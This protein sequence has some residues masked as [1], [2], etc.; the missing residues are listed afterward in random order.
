MHVGHVED[1]HAQAGIDG[2]QGAQGLL[3][4]AEEQRS[5][6]VI[7]QHTGQIGGGCPRGTVHAQQA[8]FGEVDDALDEQDRGQTHADGHGNDHVEQDGETEAGEQ[9]H[10][11]AARRAAQ[12]VHEMARL[13]HVPCGHE[14]ETRERRHR[15]IGQQIRQGDD[16]DEHHA[17]MD[18]AGQRRAGSGADVGRGAGDGGRGR[19]TA[20][21][22]RDDVAQALPHQ[23]GIGIVARARHAVGDHGAQQRFQRAQHGDGKGR[24]EQIL[25]QRQGQLER[26]AVRAG[27]HP[28][29][30][31]LRQEGRDAV[32]DLGARRPREARAN[33]VHGPFGSDSRQQQGQQAPRQQRHQMA[34]KAQTQTRPK[35][36]DPQR[37]RPDEQIGGVETGQGAQQDAQLVPVMAFERPNGQPQEILQLQGGDHDRDAAG[38]AHRDRVGHQLDEAA[39]ARQAHEQQDHAGHGAGGEQ[40]AEAEALGDGQQHHH[41]CSRRPR[42]V[43]A[44][45]ARERDQG[46]GH[47]GRIE[48][49]LGRDAAG[50][51]QG[52]GERQGDDADGDAGG[53]VTDEIA[54]AVAAGQGVP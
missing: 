10:H 5:V 47:D 4:R 32:A 54:P 26:L 18:D 31:P 15:Q 42:N 43:D 27:L 52:H 38:E 9:H 19:D 8:A 1:E 24:A 33:G 37:Q 39:E 51:G 35:D 49:L 14:Q 45:A 30:L 7:D 6:D 44:R 40:T 2:V 50:D 22:G 13:A 16:G 34:R 41:E 3:R 36:H 23:L 21:K 28:G 17:G 46:A 20:K 11:V 53:E 12:H 48:P 25:Q 29:P